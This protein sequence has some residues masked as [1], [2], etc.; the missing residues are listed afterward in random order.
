MTAADREGAAAGQAQE[1]RL[2]R[3][4]PPLFH[5]LAGGFKDTPEHLAVFLYCLF[6]KDV[7]ASA[8]S[9]EQATS[10]LY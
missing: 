3:R 10:I 1:G 5:T 7:F 6:E 2:K 4:Q 9:T 8:E